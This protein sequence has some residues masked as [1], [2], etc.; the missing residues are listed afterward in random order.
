MSEPGATYPRAG[1]PKYPFAGHME[2]IEH[3]IQLFPMLVQYQ[4]RCQGRR[5]HDIDLTRTPPSGTGGHVAFGIC[6]FNAATSTPRLSHWSIVPSGETLPYG[7]C[8]SGRA[9]LRQRS[10]V[11]RIRCRETYADLTYSI[12]NRISGQ[13][14]ACDH[15]VSQDPRTRIDV[16]SRPHFPCRQL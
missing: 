3:T 11:S 5:V 6:R 9:Q 16:F 2:L 15:L 14:K 13:R 12:V 7:R 8:R 10:K 1:E 4:S